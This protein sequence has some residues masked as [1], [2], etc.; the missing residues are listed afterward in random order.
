MTMSRG[1]IFLA[2]AL[3]IAAPLGLNARAEEKAKPVSDREFAEETAK[4]GMAEVKLG[5]LAVE[6]A[7]NPDVK[8]FGQRMIED[9]RMANKEFMTIAK[10]KEFDL[11]SATKELTGKDKELY[12]SLSKQTGA[13]FDKAYMKAMLEDHKKDVAMFESMSKN[14]KD[15]DL[16]AFATKTLPVLRE[17]LKMAQEIAT[18]VGVREGGNKDR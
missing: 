10:K 2:V 3:F 15:E 11:A 9:H 17:H 14:G 12:D 1:T 7:S 4:G 5:E 18:K 13:D 16:K 6:R 8:K